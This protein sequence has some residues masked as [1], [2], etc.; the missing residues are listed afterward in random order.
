MGQLFSS[1]K[2]FFESINISKSCMSDCCIK[3]E[4]HNETIII[5]EKEHH[6]HKHKHKHKKEDNTEDNL[7]VLG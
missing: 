2:T 6:H 3:V 7:G 4:N 5:K 1:L